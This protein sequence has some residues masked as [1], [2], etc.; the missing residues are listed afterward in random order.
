MFHIAKTLPREISPK[1]MPLAIQARS[2]A[3]ET[4]Q[5]ERGSPQIPLPEAAPDIASQ[6]EKLADLKGKG[7][8]TEDEF[9]GRKAELLGRM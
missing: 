5:A 2:A 1:L 8:L 9:A 6:I 3:K 4:S 7:I